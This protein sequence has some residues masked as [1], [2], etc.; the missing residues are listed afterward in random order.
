M[1]RAL[2]SAQSQFVESVFYVWHTYVWYAASRAAGR[3]VHRVYDRFHGFLNRADDRFD[4]LLHRVHD[5]LYSFLHRIQ[6][7]IQ[8]LLDWAQ[9]RIED[10][11]DRVQDLFRR[12]Y[13]TPGIRQRNHWILGY[14]RRRS[15]ACGRRHP[16]ETS[17]ARNY[18]R[19]TGRWLAGCR[20]RGCRGQNSRRRKGLPDS[21]NQITNQHDRAPDEE[22]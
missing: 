3:G 21:R 8:S 19:Q 16:T 18:G 6:D 2:L 13:E 17:Y 10:A 11:L 4:R 9:H 22:S 5:R 7:G 14:G 1:K 12:R 20:S 15:L